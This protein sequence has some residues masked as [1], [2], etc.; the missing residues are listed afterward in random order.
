MARRAG[1]ER[2]MATRHADL[3]RELN[4]R[5]YAVLGDLGSED[6][7]F[8]CEC[9]DESCTET[10]QLTLR[11]YAALREAG[12]GSVLRARTHLERSAQAT[13]A[14]ANAGRRR[15]LR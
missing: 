4:E 7:D 8:V 13:R 10:V 9:D 14:P 12:D 3:M 1:R 11:E 5:I 6:G 15:A 2:S